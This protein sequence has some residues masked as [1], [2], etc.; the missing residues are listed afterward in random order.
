MHASLRRLL[1]ELL[2]WTRRWLGVQGRLYRTNTS[3][4]NILIVHASTLEGKFQ[5]C[6]RETKKRK[7][8]T[9]FKPEKI[10]GKTSIFFGVVEGQKRPAVEP[11]LEF[12]PC[13]WRAILS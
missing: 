1:L 13:G 10:P 6:R 2:K 5:V 12:L 11:C 7:P 3:V 8:S 4:L 9:D